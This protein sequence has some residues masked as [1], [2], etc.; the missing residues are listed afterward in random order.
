MK[1]LVEYKLERARLMVKSGNDF[2]VEV[3]NAMPPFIEDGGY[4]SYSEK[5]IGVTFDTANTFVPST[6]IQ[7][8][9]QDLKDRA[10]LAG[11]SKMVDNESV[12]MS[13]QEISDYVDTFL[14]DRGFSE[15]A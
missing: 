13:V 8:S 2:I 4:M 11:M 10:L 5:F 14:S 15:L 7:P 1:K 12:P 6:L 3:Q 9:R